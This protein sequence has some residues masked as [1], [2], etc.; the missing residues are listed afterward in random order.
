[1]YTVYILQSKE[2]G[3]YYVGY[4]SQNPEERLSKHLSNH[5]GFSSTAKDWEIVKT[6]EFTD[7]KEALQMEKKIKKRGIRRFLESL[8]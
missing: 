6:I 5:H 4:T 1:M 3:I 2:K 7:K 8:Q